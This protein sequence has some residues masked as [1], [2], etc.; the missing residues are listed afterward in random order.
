MP[1]GLEL[2]VGKTQ[3]AGL[4]KVVMRMVLQPAG[5]STQ[6]VLWSGKPYSSSRGVVRKIGTNLSLIHCLRIQFQL[7]SHAEEWSPVHRVPPCLRICNG[8]SV[9]RNCSSFLIKRNKQTYSTEPNNLKARNSFRYNGLIHRKTVGVE[10]AADGKGVVVVMKRRS[11]QRKPATSYVRTT[12]NKNAR[13]T[14][15]SIRHMIRKNKYRPN[16]LMAAIRRT[17][18]ILRSQKPVVMRGNGPVPPRALEPYTSEAIKSLLT[19]FNHQ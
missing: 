4:D 14:L 1:E 7:A 9:V 3:N 2:H 11:G 12:I 16:L 17:S 6:L 5:V 15:S 19:F 10:P 18:A 8:W 13:A